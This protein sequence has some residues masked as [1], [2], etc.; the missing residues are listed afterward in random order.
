MMKVTNQQRR[1]R[2]DMKKE[3]KEALDNSPVIAAI[4]DEEGLARCSTCESQVVFILYGDICNISDIVDFPAPVGPTSAMPTVA[5]VFSLSRPT[6]VSG[7]ALE[8]ESPVLSVWLLVESIFTEN[9][10]YRFPA[11]VVH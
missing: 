2:C 9:C 5:I 1:I 6:S 3:F 10:I 8:L 7:L 11:S 4:K